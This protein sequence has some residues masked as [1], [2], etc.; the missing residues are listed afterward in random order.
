MSGSKTIRRIAIAHGPLIAGI[1]AIILSTAGVIVYTN[2][3]LHSI[4]NN[5]PS[6]LL[7]ELNSL[8]NALDSLGDVATSAR[9]AAATGQQDHLARLRSDIYTTYRLI[10]DLRN[11]Y[12]TDNLINAS[13]FHAAVAP[14]IADVRIWLDEG[15]SGYG[16]DSEV[17]LSII[18]SRVAE[19][20]A[21][22]SKI[23]ND[24]RNAAQV[25]LDSQ[26]KRLETFQDSVN[27]LFA[28]TLFLV[29]LLVLLLIRQGRATIRESE[30]RDEL[31]QQHDLLDSLLHSIPQGIAV[32][33]R[34]LDI[35]HLNSGFTAIT[36]YN[37]N[38]L[39]NMRNWPALAYPDRDYRRT[40]VRHWKN[41]S[42][43]GSACEYR[44][45]C[46]DGQSRDI[47][48]RAVHLTDSRIITTLSDVTER[49]RREKEIQESRLVEARA[50]KMESLGLLAGG[51]AHDLNNILSGIVSYPEL[52]LLEM[53]PDDRLRRPIELMRESGLRASAIVQDLLTVARGVAVEKEPINLNAIVED[54]L[55]SP[56]F[57]TVQR[58][59]PGVEVECV[60][61]DDLANIMGSRVHIRKILMNLVSNAFEASNGRAGIVRI[62]TANREVSVPPVSTSDL[63]EGEYVI[64]TVSDQG[65]GISAEDLEK[66][67]EPFYSK[68]VMGRSGTGLGL[69]V[70]WNVVQDHQGHI[71]VTSSP[72]GT[73]FIISLPRTSRPARQP[74]STTDLSAY[75]G[76]GETILV[77][78]DVA[79]Q[80]QIT[81]SILEKLGYRA[82][83][84]T[85]GEAAVKFVANQPVDLVLL[86]MIMSPGISGRETYE[87]I[88]RLHP[89]QKALIVSGYAETEDVRETL[90]MGA[91]AFLK[92]PMM[93]HDLA[94][95][96]H[97]ILRT[98]NEQPGIPSS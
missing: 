12:V 22:A 4:E 87:R 72:A 14:A 85:G 5:L 35:I 10:V 30:A 17:T 59:H 43:D 88:I 24:S 33:D 38:D 80:R 94:T 52:I 65:K 81:C 90:R 86:D 58:Y 98:D 97:S 1:V 27:A 39:P 69:T 6:T 3:T 7:T 77:V 57:Q 46:K 78:D 20:F 45:A 61:D 51:V 32:W 13:S 91:A 84:V 68:K 50:K 60:L 79:T 53:P 55:R 36:G 66:I 82:E 40:V 54:Y 28:F 2:K 67:F 75:R 70:V 41:R 42:R 63:E 73:A 62:T 37:R 96:I 92:K 95:T 47:E 31:Q 64:L 26:R 25:I 56:D 16:P 44:V 49:N 23:Q 71:N 11:T 9:I 93:I 76:R 48:F 8:A 34:N 89:G 74:Q 21:K 15:V 19:T 83:S 18:E 29:C